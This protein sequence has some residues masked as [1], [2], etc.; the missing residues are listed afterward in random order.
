MSEI[1]WENPPGH[2]RQPANCPVDDLQIK[3]MQA[4]PE[5]WMRVRDYNTKNGASPAATRIRK[6]AYSELG[7]PN[8]W[9]V[10]ARSFEDGSAI[11]MRY[12][13]PTDE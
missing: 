1:K 10:T 6:G 9:E 13:G 4:H 2:K 3:E 8:E 5:Q 11:W 7:T 12:N